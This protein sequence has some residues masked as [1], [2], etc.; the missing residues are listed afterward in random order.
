MSPYSKNTVKRLLV[1]LV[2]AVVMCSGCVG[3]PDTAPS[4]VAISPEDPSVAA[5]PYE[6]VVFSVASMDNP[7]CPIEASWYADGAYASEGS[8]FEYIARSEGTHSIEARDGTRTLAR[9][10]VDAAV[11]PD[12]IMDTMSAYRLLDFKDDVELVVKSRKDVEDK[13]SEELAGQ[14]EQDRTNQGIFEAFGVWDGEKDLHQE[15]LLAY[16]DAVG[17]YYDYESKYFVVVEDGCDNAALKEKTTAHELV[18][19]LQDQTYGI[20]SLLDSTKENDDSYLSVLSLLEGDAT[21]F[22]QMFMGAMPISELTDLYRYVMSLESPSYDPFLYSYMLA[23][24]IYGEAFVRAMIDMYGIEYLDEVYRLPPVSTEQVLH[25]EKYLAGEGPVHVEVSGTW[26]GWD[27]RDENTIGE[28]LLLLI[29]QEECGADTAAQ[30]AEG[31]GG[32]AYGYYEKDGDFAL[33]YSSVWDTAVDAKEFFDTY[34][35]II[36]SRGA[37]LADKSPDAFAAWDSGDARIFISLAEDRVELLV[38]SSEE[39][40]GP[41]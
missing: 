23:P 7:D 25:P 24:Y 18:H 26:Q 20:S 6:T 27:A 2:V 8:A 31:W 21:Y 36:G 29:L 41:N 34:N 22:E 9:W 5:T 12:A 11:S 14:E 4:D 3:E 1:T 30:A 39:T 19:A 13:M 35:G 40:C 32:D 33:A 28:M 16:G 15:L 37:T 17:G 38:T 10:S